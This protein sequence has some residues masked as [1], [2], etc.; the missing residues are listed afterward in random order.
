[1]DLL[2]HH[3]TS[4]PVLILF[5]VGVKMK[6]AVTLLEDELVQEKSLGK[7]KFFF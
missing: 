3:D 5:G 1:M 6:E 4:C 2:T 7:K